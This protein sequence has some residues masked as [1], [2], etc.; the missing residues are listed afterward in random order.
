M[1][2]LQINSVCGIGS[3]GRIA[4]DIHKMLIE[5][6]HESYIA[7]GRELPMNCNNAIR[8]GNKFD[9]YVH[10]AKTRLFDLHGFGSNKATLE[11][12]DKV[13][14]LNPDIIHLHNIH[15]YYINI[16]ILFNFLKE[17]NKPIIWTLHDCWTFT[18][19]CSHFDYIGCERWKTGCFD[20]PEKRSYPSS[21]MLDNSKSNYY[22]KKDLF[23]GVDNLTLVTPSEWLYGLVKQSF[24][25]EYPVEVINNGIDLSVFKPSANIRNIRDIY[26]LEEKF[27]LLGV[28]N[29]WNSRKGLDS[30]FELAKYLNDDEIIILVGLTDN[31]VKD[32]PKGIIGIKRTN[33]VQEL[34]DIY[35]SAGVYINPTLE[36][37]Y[38]TTNLEALACGTPVITYNSGGSPESIDDKTG[39]IVEK[40]NIKDLIDKIKIAKSGLINENKC[41]ERAE[42]FNKDDK[43]TKYIELYTSIN[44]IKDEL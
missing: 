22:K 4:T 18:G 21:L 43:F 44:N 6:G 1:K 27:I 17:Y 2:V 14:K 9:N 15:G 26:G 29:V 25:K 31:Q 5:Q 12:I 20:C 7:F 41:I 35:S 39:F 11:F 34:V 37:T 13:E 23:T 16:E 38:P 33:N 10:A 40:G 28:A 3:T 42:M 24:L 8:I 32:M 19:H 36:D 30:F